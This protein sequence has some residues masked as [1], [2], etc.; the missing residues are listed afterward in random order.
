MRPMYLQLINIPQHMKDNISKN[1][2]YAEATKSRTAEKHGIA[3]DPNSVELKAMKFIAE[4]IF[5]KVRAHFKKPIRI[6][7]FFRG[8]D[9]NKVIPG[10]SSKSQH[11]KG[12]AIDM[13][14][15]TFGGL[16]NA[17]IF[18]YIKDNL[19]FD[20]MIW[21]HG[22][23][24][25]PSWVHVSLKEKGKNRRSLLIAYRGRDGRTKYKNYDK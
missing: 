3:N 20:Q 23:S 24:H 13:D 22:N 10:A 21:E 19:E 7:S 16:T 1:I 6:S 25:N 11:S 2:T 12:E 14:A 17:D 15:D 9:L 4:N 18:Y 5:Q 8:A